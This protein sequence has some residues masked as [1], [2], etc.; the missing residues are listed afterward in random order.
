M[1]TY[2]PDIIHK[3]A[4]S[5]MEENRDTCFFL[6][7]PSVIPH[8]ELFAPEKYMRIY[9]GKFDPEKHYEGVD[10][11]P[12][13]RQG[14]YGSQPE[15]HAAFAAMIR[16]LDDQVG[17][18]M[19]KV[20]D[21][22]LE[23]RTII[24]FSSDN[25]PHLEGGAD[26]D[27]FDSNGPLRGYK[28]DLYE[29]GMR[30]PMIVRWPGTVQAG[31]ISDHISAFWDVMPTLASIIGKPEPNGIDGIS[32][33]PVLTGKGNQQVH[34]YLYSE[35]HERGGRRAIR[36]GPW[37]L[38]QYDVNAEPPGDPQ[39]YN[40]EEDIGEDNDLSGQYPG[41][42]ER[43]FGLMLSARTPSDVFQ[44]GPGERTKAK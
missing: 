44:F 42:V 41:R 14:A 12:R 28:R 27:Y 43:M 37:K 2:G 17:E 19:M 30:V 5:F 23:D 38:V 16:L 24:M 11:G 39:L 6:Y 32:F 35:F 1:G 20:R 21:L 29:G 4:L 31:A 18:I 9:R 7:Y 15:A 8:A 36:Q 26:P 3:N 33:L 25:G 10:D 13:Y 40:L 34:E 22:G